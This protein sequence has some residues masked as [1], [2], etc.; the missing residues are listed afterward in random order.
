MEKTTETEKEFIPAEESTNKS[1][2]EATP[3]N[4]TSSVETEN[5]KDK[6]LRLTADFQNYKR[7]MEKDRLEWMTDAQV[8]LLEKLLPIF[9]EL[10]RALQ[11]SEQNTSPEQQEWLKGFLLIQK[12][13]QK[14]FND[15]QI[16]EI[17]EAITFDPEQH[18]ALMQVDTTD[19]ESGEIVQVFSKGYTFKD[20]IVKHAKVSVAK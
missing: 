12:N 13:W 3:E 15:L 20:K 2:S 19:K 9:E 5:F 8:M 1:H 14:T 6:F 18:E 10:E 7:R 4:P 17:S 16:K 11:H